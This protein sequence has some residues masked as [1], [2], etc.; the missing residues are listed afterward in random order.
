MME[1]LLGDGFGGRRTSINT[2]NLGKLMSKPM[3]V[4]SS[5]PEP[6]R[7]SLATKNSAF[8]SCE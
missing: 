7:R 4:N 5:F 3:K 8:V 6:I 1:K 2:N